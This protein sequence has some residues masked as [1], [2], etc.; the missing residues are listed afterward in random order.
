[1]SESNK[2]RIEILEQQ[3]L[4]VFDQLISLRQEI[5]EIRKFMVNDG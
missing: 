1:M 2:D 3:I 5:L 4:R